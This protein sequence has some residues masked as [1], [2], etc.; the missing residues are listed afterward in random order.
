MSS[1]SKTK[2][3][4]NITFNIDFWTYKQYIVII[5]SLENIKNMQKKIKV[6]HLDTNTVFLKSLFKWKFLAC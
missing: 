3:E 5:E 1:S 4:L 6:T 2:L